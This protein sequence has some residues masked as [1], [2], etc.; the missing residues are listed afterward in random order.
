MR[1]IERI[2]RAPGRERDLVKSLR[3]LAELELDPTTKR[4]LFREAKVLAEEQVKDLALTEQVLRQ[5]LSEDEAHL[6]ALEELTRLREAAGDFPEVLKLLLR[7]AELSTDGLELARLQHHAAEIAHSKLDDTRRAAELYETIFE[8]TPTDT[9]AATAL[10]ELYAKQ[11]RTVM[12]GASWGAS[13]MSPPIRPS[14]T[15]CAS[16]S[17]SCKPTPRATMPSKRCAACSTKTPARPKRSCSSR[18][19]TRRPGKTKS[20]PSCSILEIELAKDRGDNATELSLTVLLGEIYEVRL[21][22]TG[23]AI[24]TY[25][26]VLARDPAHRGVL[27]ALARLFEAK[28]EL[29]PSSEALEKLLAQSHGE[30]AVTPR[31]STCRCYSKLKDDEGAE[32]ALEL[33]LAQI[34]PTPAFESG[35]GKPTRRRKSGGA[36]PT[37]WRPT[38]TPPPILPS[39]CASTALPPTCTWRSRTT[40]ARRPSCSKKPAR[41]PPSIASSC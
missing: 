28:G 18:S 11:G 7:R 38:E 32:R 15:C 41:W 13:S 37:S 30:E 22:D 16:S 3:R 19:S 8:N 9:A 39:G 6:W 2:R 14:A 23:K 35:S 33:G 24:E 17:P 36:S 20:W 10:R 4:Q 1:S 26:A 40:P 29:K 21:A 25:Q 5:L 34:R 31:A 12:L 27:E